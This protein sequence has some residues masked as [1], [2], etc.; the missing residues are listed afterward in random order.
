MPILICFEPWWDIG[1]RLYVKSPDQ[2]LKKLGTL[3]HC[4]LCFTTGSCYCVCH[5]S[6][7]VIAQCKSLYTRRSSHWQTF[8]HKSLVGF[9]PTYLCVCMCRTLSPYD[10]TPRTSYRCRSQESELGKKAWKGGGK[11][12]LIT[13]ANVI[14]CFPSKNTAC[15]IIIATASL[16]QKFSLC[17]CISAK[18]L[19]MWKIGLTCRK[20]TLTSFSMLW[21][22]K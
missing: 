11:E 2:F 15:R 8:T 10:L 19:N 12:L 16:N 21:S 14:V 3:H 9:L 4:V 18:A 5:C 6:L 22:H 20:I 13:Y 7:Y 1:D 17:L